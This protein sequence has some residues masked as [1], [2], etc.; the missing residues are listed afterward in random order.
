M[1]LDYTQF[2]EQLPAT[3]YT[4]DGKLL[5]QPNWDDVSNWAKAGG[6]F[7]NPVFSIDTTGDFVYLSGYDADFYA[8]GYFMD[9]DNWC[10]LSVGAA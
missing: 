5:W 2:V 1:K 6:F 4:S 10:K 8:Y 9:Y 7:A 3:G